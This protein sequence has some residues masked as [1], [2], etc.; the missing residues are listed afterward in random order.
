MGRCLFNPADTLFTVTELD[1]HRNNLE[2]IMLG[3]TVFYFR[4]A[5]SSCLRSVFNDVDILGRLPAIESVGV[6]K[7][8]DA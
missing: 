5:P 2:Y 6:V 3:V 8:V 4:F 7:T 1:L